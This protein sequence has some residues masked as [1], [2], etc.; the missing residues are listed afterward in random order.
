MV[1]RGKPG[2]PP[3]TAKHEEFARLVTLDAPSRLR[4]RSLLQVR[5]TFAAPM[6][7]AH[8]TDLPGV[9]DLTIDGTSLTCQ[10]DG[11][12]DA[13][14]KA[15]AQHTV[16]GLYADTPDLETVFDSYFTGRGTPNDPQPAAGPR[17]IR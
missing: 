1:G 12:P 4:A 8:F 7:A 11:T 17:G 3:E 14:V 16:T 15:A 6:P 9:S 13:L 5:I 2:R 10:V